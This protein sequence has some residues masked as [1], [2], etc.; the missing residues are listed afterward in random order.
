[1]A[2]ELEGM[3][4]VQLGDTVLYGVASTLR[5][6]DGRPN[7]SIDR[8]ARHRCAD[9][10][11][12]A[13]G[14]VRPHA[15]CLSIERAQE[16]C[17]VLNA[18]QFDSPLLA[19][20]RLVPCFHGETLADALKGNR[21]WEVLEVRVSLSAVAALAAGRDV[22]LISPIDPERDTVLPSDPSFS[23]RDR[24]QTVVVACNPPNDMQDV[25]HDREWLF[26]AFGRRRLRPLVFDVV[27]SSPEDL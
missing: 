19:S 9:T 20:A 2:I 4:F 1:M 7:Q 14:A 18:Q 24:E 3:E 23:E 22:A 21:R 6:F 15:V 25:R 5:V 12:L 8:A 10:G 13:A 16:I 26:H 17:D 27:C 11:A